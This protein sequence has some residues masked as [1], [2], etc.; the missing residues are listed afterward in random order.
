MLFSPSSKK[1]VDIFDAIDIFPM[2]QPMVCHLIIVIQFALCSS[3]TFE[4]ACHMTRMYES[5]KR[6]SF[7][8][9]SVV[10]KIHSQLPS[11]IIS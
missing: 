10:L 2:T 9:E 6:R 11:A 7:E 3:D 8:S 5:I 4:E 1:A